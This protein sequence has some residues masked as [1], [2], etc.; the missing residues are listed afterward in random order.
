MPEIRAAAVDACQ[1]RLGALWLYCLHVMVVKLRP[2]FRAGQELGEAA[3]DGFPL[4][5]TPGLVLLLLWCL[6]VTARRLMSNPGMEMSQEHELT[7][8]NYKMYQD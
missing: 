4:R 2:H 5:V 7:W 6:Y 1:S 8:M 3:A